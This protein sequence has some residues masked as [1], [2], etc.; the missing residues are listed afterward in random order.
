M[1]ENTRFDFAVH[2]G[3]IWV[4][5]MMPLTFGALT[6]MGWTLWLSRI[7]FKARQRVKLSL[8]RAEPKTKGNLLS[9][10]SK[11][12][13]SPLST[14]SPVQLNRDSPRQLQPNNSNHHKKGIPR[15]MKRWI[16]ICIIL[17]NNAETGL[18]NEDY[19]YYYDAN[20]NNKNNLYLKVWK[21]KVGF[22]GGLVSS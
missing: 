21:N 16:N 11:Q 5:W 7:E 17:E 6:W 20:S 9:F 4:W 22:F 12:K 15:E 8:G 3:E 18:W 1:Y 2:D 13:K 14:P 19:D 10:P